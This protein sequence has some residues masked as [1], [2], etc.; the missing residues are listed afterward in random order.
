M[1]NSNDTIYRNGT[2]LAIEAGTYTAEG[3]A[4]TMEEELNSI[5]TGHTVTYDAA[6][7]KFS[8]TNNTGVPVVFNWSRN[9]ASDSSIGGLLGFDTIDSYIQNRPAAL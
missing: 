6:T 2:P 4:K 7:G 1:T 9:S 3:L 8:I 5:Q